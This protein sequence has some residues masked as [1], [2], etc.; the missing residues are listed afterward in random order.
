MELEQQLKILIDDASNYGVSPLVMQRAI[1]PVLALLA[2]QLDHVE[3]YV[4]QNLEEDWILTTIRNQAQP[5]REKK[6]IYAFA[7]LQDAATF[8]GSADPNILAVSLPVTHILFKLF[9]LQQVDS[10][11]FLKTPGNLQSGTEIERAKLQ[12]LIQQ[13]IQQLNKIPPNIA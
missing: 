3:Y 13:Q 6:V 9:P 5:E 10:I 2:Q 12:L 8:Q 7:T 11:I 4:L 1:T